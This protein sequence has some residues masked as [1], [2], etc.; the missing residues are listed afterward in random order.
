MQHIWSL[1]I[2]GVDI[3]ILGPDLTCISEMRIK[4]S[5]KYRVA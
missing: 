5:Y 2:L 3:Y 1:K 4:E